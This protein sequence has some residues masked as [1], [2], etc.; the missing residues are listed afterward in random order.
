MKSSK[1]SKTLICSLLAFSATA[2]SI[3]PV[4]AASPQGG[5]IATTIQAAQG[6]TDIAALFKKTNFQMDSAAEYGTVMQAIA[7]NESAAVTYVQDSR[8][9]ATEVQTTHPIW[10]GVQNGD[11]LGVS[12]S[13]GDFQHQ[14]IFV[15]EG[16]GNAGKWKKA[17][18]AD[19]PLKQGGAPSILNQTPLMPLMPQQQVRETSASAKSVA[20]VVSVSLYR[21]VTGNIDI[22]T[23]KVGSRIQGIYGVGMTAPGW[24][25]ADG[26]G[27]DIVVFQV[28]ASGTPGLFYSGVAS[29]T[30][31]RE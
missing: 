3:H 27:T 8:L 30:V 19:I 26:V 6:Q 13:G 12:W 29:A 7:A 10:S 2:F 11:R 17:E 14:R 5:K 15:Y 4:L 9:S 25:Q 28:R 22:Y 31:I 24:I 16:N 1:I 20:D 18:A 21:R 23:V